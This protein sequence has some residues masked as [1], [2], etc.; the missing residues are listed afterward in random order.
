M[1]VVGGQGSIPSCCSIEKPS[2][3]V[4]LKSTTRKIN[5]S[6]FRVLFILSSVPQPA[7]QDMGI[8]LFPKALKASIWSSVTEIC[9][10]GT[11]WRGY[12]MLLCQGARAFLFV[13]HK[14]LTMCP[15]CTLCLSCVFCTPAVSCLPGLLKCCAG[16]AWIPSLH[17]SVDGGGQ[18]LWELGKE[19]GR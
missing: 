4:L 16:V 8:I 15:G 13:S 18:G 1:V 6:L 12:V 14:A 3:L 10:W 5:C 11:G 7:L 9:I 19:A 17:L 2:F